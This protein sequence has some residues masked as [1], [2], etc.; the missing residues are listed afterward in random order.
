MT[1]ERTS[2]LVP[3]ETSQQQLLQVQQNGPV[4]VVGEGARFVGEGAGLHEED[5]SSEDDS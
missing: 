3:M 5:N 1:E 2:S 4:G